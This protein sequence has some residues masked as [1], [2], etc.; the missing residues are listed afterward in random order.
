MIRAT[1]DIFVS[2]TG[3]VETPALLPTSPYWAVQPP[4]MTSSLPVIQ[5]TCN[6]HG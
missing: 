1:A 2:S 5:P 6:G 4:S 3:I